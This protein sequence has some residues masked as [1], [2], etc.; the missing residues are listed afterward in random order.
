MMDFYNEIEPYPARW[1]EKLIA[2]GH[3]PPGTVSRMDIRKINPAMIREYDQCH[4]FNGIGGWPYALKLAGFETVKS[5]WTG[6]CPCQP[7][8]VSG[9]GK[10]EADERHLWPYFR[11]LIK[12]G[13]PTIVFGEQVASPAGR[14]WL[15]R[16]RID[17]EN[18]GYVVGG[19]DLCAPGVGAPHIRQRLFW[20]AVRIS[21]AESFG[22]KWGRAEGKG[23]EHNLQAIRIPDANRERFEK[24]RRAKS[25]RKKNAGVEYS[26]GLGNGN[27][28][29]RRGQGLP[30][31]P[32][33]DE[34]FILAGSGPWGDFE[35]VEFDELRG[36]KDR[37][38]K[39][40]IMPVV[41]GI[42]G[43]VGYMRPYERRRQI[44][45]YGNAIVPQLAAVFIECFMESIGGDS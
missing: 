19:A 27:G 32:G 8:S 37:R 25:G 20:G 40:G 26:C 23:S 35:T 44:A 4:F 41:N 29:R 22:S 1:T 39:P 15:S 31:Q 13:K 9:K 43:A 34:D 16:V 10:G 42:P 12:F 17:L 3:L 14:Q 7:F 36:K 18:L 33:Q 6:S 24:Q 28:A 45:A 21:D 2:A 30:I 11:E 5:I 38:I